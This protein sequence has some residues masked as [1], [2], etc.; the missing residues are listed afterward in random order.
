MDAAVTLRAGLRHEAVIGAAQ[1]HVEFGVVR[2]INQKQG[3]INDLSRD[4]ATIHIGKPGRDV[5]Q[6]SAPDL[7]IASVRLDLR[8][9]WGDE[10]EAA[11]AD[12][13]GENVAV[14]EPGRI[15]IAV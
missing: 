15:P 7:N 14:D 3:R 12:R 10:T 11:F 4:A 6:L 8:S 9:R 2:E 1:C 13:L 5:G